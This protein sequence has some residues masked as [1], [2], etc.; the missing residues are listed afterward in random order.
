[1]I[2]TIVEQFSAH[3]IKSNSEPIVDADAAY[4]ISYAVIIL[5]TDQHN[6]NHNNTPMTVM[7]FVVLIRV[8]HDHSIGNHIRCICIHNRL[9]VALNPMCR[10]LF[11]QA[12]LPLRDVLISLFEKRNLC[13]I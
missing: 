6:K 2:A 10:K 1:M 5:N 4:V 13:F 7:I 12:T 3:W 11:S 9:T 8:Q